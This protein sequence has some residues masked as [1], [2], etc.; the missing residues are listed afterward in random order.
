MRTITDVHS[1][2]LPRGGAGC[3]SAKSA[4]AT[5]KYVALDLDPDLDHHS[6][7]RIKPLRHIENI[8]LMTC[9]E[10]PLRFR[11]ISS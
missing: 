9:R 8:V 10:P 3:R 1:H 6:R 5:A 7:T 11:P 2:V 4:V